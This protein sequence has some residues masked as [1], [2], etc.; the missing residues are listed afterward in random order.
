MATTTRK[1]SSLREI[2]TQKDVKLENP[3]KPKPGCQ[4]EDKR[5]IQFD[6]ERQQ[7]RHWG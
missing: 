2:P 7:K 5:R 4:S 6:V 3:P 1:K